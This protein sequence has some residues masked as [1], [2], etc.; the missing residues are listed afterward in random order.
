MNLSNTKDLTAYLTL[1]ANNVNYCSNRK[2]I[3]T[4]DALKLRQTILGLGWQVQPNIGE[5]R[6]HDQLEDGFATP[7]RN[8][9]TDPDT[10]SYI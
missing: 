6:T 4:E 7:M 10:F 3:S 2:Y 5:K 9:Q 8:A 1:I